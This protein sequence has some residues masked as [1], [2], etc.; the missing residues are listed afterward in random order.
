[1]LFQSAAMAF[2][3]MVSGANSNRR[4]AAFSIDASSLEGYPH[5]SNSSSIE[6]GAIFG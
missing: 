5:R 1:V 3:G 6:A 2:H 4:F